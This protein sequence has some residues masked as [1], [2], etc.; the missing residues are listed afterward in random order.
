MAEVDFLGQGWK[1]PISLNDKNNIAL[2]A[3]EQSIKESIMIILSTSKGERIMR[4]N[5]GCN[6]QEL[7]FSLN[8]TS[9]ATQVIFYVEEALKEWEPRIDLFKVDAMPDEEE[10]NKLNIFID[11]IVIASNNRYNLVYPFYLEKQ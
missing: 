9:T 4:P 10:R 1:H 3:G 2:S 11:Y 7:V 5:F 8:N 6:L